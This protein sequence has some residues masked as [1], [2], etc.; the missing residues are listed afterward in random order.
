M[1]VHNNTKNLPFVF[2]QN[3]KVVDL[4]QLFHWEQLTIYVNGNTRVLLD[5]KHKT[6]LCQMTK[7]K[8]W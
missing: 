7:F 5:F 4:N 1:Y 2:L 8:P 3:M 6:I